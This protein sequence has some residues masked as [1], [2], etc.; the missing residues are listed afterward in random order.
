MKC[1]RGCQ[2]EGVLTEG[3]PG[4]GSAGRY[5]RHE[6]GPN[7]THVQAEFQSGA[8]VGGNFSRTVTQILCLRGQRD[9]EPSLM[10]PRRRFNEIHPD[11]EG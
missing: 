2:A 1:L 10:R 6:T 11:V 7:V 5:G 3:G 8:S 9:P 4:T